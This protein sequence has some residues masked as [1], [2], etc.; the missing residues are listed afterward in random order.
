LGIAQRTVHVKHPANLANQKRANVLKLN[1]KSVGDWLKFK[2]LE[3]NL[4]LGRVAAKM[5]IA[6]SLVYAWENNTQ[7]P[8]NH[9]L[10]VLSSVL[11]FD[12][13]DFENGYRH[14]K[15]LS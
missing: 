15:K 14:P 2:R 12:A 9:Q 1:I 4:T 3:R 10:K 5:G 13:K 8:K 7:Q 6:A 11:E